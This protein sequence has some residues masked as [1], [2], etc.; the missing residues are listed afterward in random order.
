M[1]NRAKCKVCG[2]ILE[3]FHEHDWVSCK[4]AEISICGGNIRL[5]CAAKDWKNFLRVDDLDHIIVP[6]VVQ[7]D[8]E[9]LQQ[10]DNAITLQSDR[11]DFKEKL[12]ML[13][14]MVNHFEELPKHVMESPINHYDFYSMALVIISLL[15]QLDPQPSSP[16]SSQD[17]QKPSD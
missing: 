2:D 14:S 16:Q 3:S 17:P 10:D 12:D 9:K 1:R 4:C 11:P 6:K 7:K 8:A 13:K 5:E 15:E